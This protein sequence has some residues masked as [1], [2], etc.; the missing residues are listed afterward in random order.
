MFDR[1]HVVGDRSFCFDCYV[2]LFSYKCCQCD[3]VISPES[4]VSP[5]PYFQNLSDANC[6]NLLIILYVSQSDLVINF[7]EG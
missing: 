2:S 4:R 7:W 1:F 6:A 3:A 5:C